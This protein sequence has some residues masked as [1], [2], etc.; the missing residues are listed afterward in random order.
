[1]RAVRIAAN[2][3]NLNQVSVMRA[4]AL[5]TALST[6]SASLLS[7]QAKPPASDSAMYQT[8]EWRN[9]GPFR[10]GRAVAAAEIGRAHV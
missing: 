4:L 3:R 9:I 6:V 1:M 8:L 7:A 10:G 2:V 5:A